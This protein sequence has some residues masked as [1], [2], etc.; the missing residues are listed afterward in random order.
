LQSGDAVLHPKG[1][2]FGEK[3]ADHGRVAPRLPRRQADLMSDA[4]GA[5]TCRRGEE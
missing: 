1:V 4:V 2:D 3:P 5:K